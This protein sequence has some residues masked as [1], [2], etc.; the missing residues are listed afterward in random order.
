[1]TSTLAAIVEEHFECD[2]LECVDDAEGILHVPPCS[3]YYRPRALA[4][5]MAVREEAAKVAE[6]A[7]LRVAFHAEDQLAVA[8]CSRAMRD[9]IADA[10]RAL[11]DDAKGGA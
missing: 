11:G 2:G 9:D 3:A 8:A 4:V 5:A 7:E 1:M 6:R 10:I